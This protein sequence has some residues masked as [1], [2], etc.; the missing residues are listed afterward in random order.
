MRRISVLL[1]E[2][3]SRKL[4]E[5]IDENDCS[6]SDAINASVIAFSLCGEKVISSVE[7]YHKDVYKIIGDVDKWCES[8]SIQKSRL[9]YVIN[10]SHYGH[11]VC[12]FGNTKNKWRDKQDGRLF[13][14][15]TAWIA[16]CL[17]EDFGI[18]LTG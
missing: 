3:T 15:H 11:T 18:D 6:I 4:N 8:R 7:N 9:R 5:I 14:T 13:K 17:K 1:D 12:G 16:H 10:S 2:I